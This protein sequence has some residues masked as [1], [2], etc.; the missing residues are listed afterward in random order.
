MSSF[1]FDTSFDRDGGGGG[2]LTSP[3]GIADGGTGGTTAAQA[4]SNLNVPSTSHTHALD[5]GAVTGILPVNKGGTGVNL[6]GDN[7]ALKVSGGNILAGA[8]TAA[9]VDSG[10]ATL[11][12]VL[13]ADGAGGTSW[14]DA[15]AG[16]GGNTATALLLAGNQT[17]NSPGFEEYITGLTVIAPSNN[18]SQ[19]TWNPSTDRLTCNTAGILSIDYQSRIFSQ[20][21][22][23]SGVALEHY[24]N[25][26]N[27]LG[28]V[29]GAAEISSWDVG[30]TNIWLR[31]LLEMAA[32]DYLRPMA[33]A[34]NASEQHLLTL[35]V[36][37]EGTA[38]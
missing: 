35:R 7:G 11:G 15:S 30:A 8:I 18:P 12:Q 34:T 14:E 29:D 27:L 22:I 13:T 21:L 20:N 4:R 25:G 16:G 38:P 23:D 1:D 24:D 17:L 2:G 32:G 19:L 5:G 31:A 3:V 26:G 28:F 6:S 36:K 9:D 10:E 37:W 33:R